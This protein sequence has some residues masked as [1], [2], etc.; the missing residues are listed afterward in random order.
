LGEKQAELA[1]E[2]GTTQGRVSQLER[3]KDKSLDNAGINQAVKDIAVEKLME[4]LNLI[5]PAKLQKETAQGLSRVASNMAKVVNLTQEQTKERDV[6][7]IV[8]APELRSEK[9]FK[10]ID[11]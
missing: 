8:Y 11:V 3:G 5:T 1:K 2:F 4:S 6:T 10:S 7:V 9:S